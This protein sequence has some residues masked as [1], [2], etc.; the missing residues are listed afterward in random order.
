MSEE[1]ELIKKRGSYKGR[2]TTFSTYLNGLN[3]SLLTATDVSE[4]QLRI[5]KMK[6]VFEQ[7]DEVQLSLECI[8]D[9]LELHL[10][11]RNEFES[12]YYKLIARA[13][14]LV[15]NYSG[16]CDNK[17]V[18]SSSCNKLVKLPTIQLPKFS[19]AY[20]NWL[21]FHDTFS[22]LIHSNSEISDINKFH[23]LRTSLEGTAAIVIQSIQFCAMNYEAAWKLLCDRFDSK[24]LLIHNHVSAL[25]NMESVTKESSS[26]LKRLIDNFNKNLLA[27]KSLGEPVNYWDTL[28]IYVISNKLDS[29]TYRKWEE[30]KELLNKGEPITLELFNTFL[31]NHAD[32]LENIE[33]SFSRS[34]QVNSNTTH[35]QN[36]KIKTM[37]SIQNNSGNNS[38]S[39]Q[40][41]KSCPMCKSGE[42]NLNTCSQFLAL[43]NE[44]RYKLLPSFKVCYN[45][46]SSGHF[47]NRC[48]RQGCKL[49]KRKHNTIIH[50][51]DMA[52]QQKPVT[53]S[54]SKQSTDRA[55]EAP[56]DCVAS[57]VAPQLTHMTTLS[58]N[59]ERSSRGASAPVP[60]DNS[61]G[62]VLL[63]TALIKLFDANNREHIARAVLDSGSTSCLI[64]EK[65]F[66]KL[67]LP[68]EHINKSILGINS[69]STKI[70]KLCNL[71][72]KSLDEQFENNIQCFVLP[73]I[74]SCVP[75]R[76]I[77][78]RNLNIP[79]DIMLADP[80][81]H[82]PGEVH[83]IIGADVFWD[84]LGTQKLKLGNGKPTLYET[85][86]GWLVSGH[87]NGAY[88]SSSSNHIKCN[89]VKNE[90]IDSSC[91]DDILTQLTRFWQLEEVSPK[92]SSLY[93]REEQL[94]EDHFVQN[95]IRLGD[96][97]FCVRIPL[98]ENPMV[99]G[100]SF[101]RAK[102]CF[103]SL[104][105]RN[106][107]KPVLNKLY[108]DFMLEYQSLGHMSEC[109]QLNISN[110]LFIPHHGILRED[111]STTKLRAV[112][113]ASS[114]TTSG[115]SLNNIQMVGPQVQ[116]DLLSILIRF[117]QHRYVLSA[118]VE[119][120]YRQV[121]VH[122]DDRHLQHILWRF[123]STE[124]I[125]S[126][127]LN[128]VTYGTAS[129]PFLATRCLKQLG[130]SCKDSRISEII[131]ND[132]YVDDL[133]TGGTEINELLE[134]R[135]KVTS[136]LASAGMPLR[137][138]RSNDSQLESGGVLSSKDLNIGTVEPSKT[139]GLGW[140]TS[141][142]QLCFPIGKSI[143]SCNSKRGILSVIAQIF[144]PL[145][146]LAPCVIRMKLILQRLWLDKLSWDDQLSP[147]VSKIWEDIINNLPLLN[148]IRVPRHAMSARCKIIELH[149]FTD[150]SESAY[151]SC[152][153]VR[154][155][156]EYG[157]IL[158][159]LLIAKSRVAPI[160]PLTIPRL[161][162]C[163]AVIGARLFEKALSSLRITV[164]KVVF[165]TDS[166]IVLGWLKML[167]S[168]LQPFVRNRVA[169]ILEKTNN[170]VWRHVPTD[171]NPADYLTRGI[172]FKLMESLDI[173]WSGPS[174]LLQDVSHW[175]ANVQQ[176]DKLPE[177][178]PI[179][180]HVSLIDRKQ[181]IFIDFNRFSNLLRLKRCV[182]Y[183]LRFVKRCQGLSVAYEYLTNNELSNAMVLLIKISQE[184]SFPE[185]NLLLNKQPLPKKSPLLKFSIFLDEDNVM[186]VG[187]RLSNSVFSFDKKFPIL[188]QSTHRLTKL[189]FKHEHLKLLHAG[190]QLMLSSIRE[191]Y[192][193]IGGRN[194]AKTC[195]HQCMLC[196]RMKGKV[197]APQM[198]NLPQSRLTCGAVFDSVGVDYAGPIA[199]VSRQG[200]GSRINKVYIA[201]FI[202]FTTK[203][204][205][206]ELVG[207]LT[208]QCYISALRRFISRRGKPQNIYSDNGTSFV[209]AYNELSKFLKNNC[210]SVAD[211]VA[212]DGI[213]FHFI[214]AYAPHF[215][216]LWEAGV[217]STKY[218]LVRVLGNCHLTYE[219]LY[220]TLVQI[221][222][223]LNSRPLT[224]ISSDPEDMTP[225]TP[226]HFLIGRPL[227]A[228]PDKSYEDCAYNNLTR[229]ERIQQLREHFWI[230]WS[231]EYVSELQQR[232]KWRNSNDP[233]K[234]N[235]L[236]VLKEDHL[237]P[238][239]WR[240][241]R[242]VAVHPGSDG[243][244]RVADIR[245]SSG[246]VR[247]AF[248]RIC[249][250]PE[251]SS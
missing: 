248:S 90:S 224:P 209:G 138:W 25:F 237:P 85:K 40:L 20:E 114:P 204:I 14:T 165:W 5:G 111:S 68:A 12:S 15:S 159:R 218:H 98:K 35:K 72:F 119:K 37:V 158:V 19:G 64:T 219:E 139:L 153:Y 47:A 118:D 41:T 150:A 8:S 162:L 168:R 250:L 214:P 135:E 216:G 170:H 83:L 105:R 132:F 143:A 29:K 180:L 200:R 108:K 129:A 51:S 131:I 127:Q 130:V 124:P 152:A 110:S 33:L 3:I 122:P 169:D 181:D 21:E 227:T 50:L 192:W 213:N 79:T 115:V 123:N 55:A 163:G 146:L 225:L 128:T 106:K 107:C 191:T 234:L 190:P 193:P 154:S 201:I 58:V 147:E 205:H 97:R 48:K 184:Q 232:T 100:D 239:K 117:R 73:T 199:S 75:S 30:H 164:S 245:T 233:L 32:L 66:N 49:C 2:L 226:G 81:F 80:N 188:L 137:K 34:Q 121:L 148:N 78:L 28:L 76:N 24:R 61:Q 53:S 210:N 133:L 231:K 183:V 65:M 155:I 242:I 240:L 22:S 17:S 203:A 140:I 185:Y 45:C 207:D 42:H 56:E 31:R 112:F 223:V 74:T 99:L 151:G 102:H 88:M 202:C 247:R 134:I 95:T 16:E 67:N 215:G 241:G 59:H 176:I 84:I 125:K 27:L 101:K 113:N 175:P 221:E 141:S 160:K 243:I 77:D 60:H 6:T 87:I 71:R 156:S 246:I 109:A 44:S 229:F 91:N 142:D 63:S 52:L 222:A 238:L 235:S 46:F 103:L 18:N 189:I 178:K 172:D 89:L 220:S 211:M 195:Y 93:S 38:S 70:N 145:G 171:L 230:R 251:D 166:T 179:S 167:P 196:S 26:N 212:N 177:I 13:Q 136:V 161:E 104:E 4:L 149:I 249:P 174:F 126:F 186:R 96:G 116:D 11:D 54:A 236:V 82:S 197:V 94:C 1:K 36:N 57:A 208:S 244:S 23:Y 7:Y 198:G 182:A 173:W 217:K 228:L 62:E 187:G 9:N 69:V 43:N 194:L 86:L 206:L 144:D 157:E 120:M 92:S 10:S 39:T